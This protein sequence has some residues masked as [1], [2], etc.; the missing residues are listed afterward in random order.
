MPFY[1]QAE[2]VVVTTLDDGTFLVHP[3]TQEIYFLDALAAG[4][5]SALAE[6]SDETELADLLCEAFP[7][8]DPA[9]V[10]TDLA[11]LLADLLARDL[12]V[13]A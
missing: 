8:I 10:R 6:P 9:T 3:A 1:G 5:W 4:V 2:G 7:E 12:A 11:R 13:L